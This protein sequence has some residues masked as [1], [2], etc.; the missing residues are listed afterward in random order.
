MNIDQNE[1]LNVPKNKS[2]RLISMK[3]NIVSDKTVINNIETGKFEPPIKLAEKL[4]KFLGIKLVN[5]V[6]LE[7]YKSAS[8][9]PAS[10]EGM[11]L[12]DMIKVK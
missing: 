12:G 1:N 7:G 10:S 11:T 8:P 6:T 4:E 3:N 2:I 5:E 9:S